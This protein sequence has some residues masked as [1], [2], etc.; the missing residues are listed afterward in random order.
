MEMMVVI[1]MIMVL[2]M[3]VMVNH[4]CGDGGDDDGEP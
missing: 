3:M 4:D 2:V 1:M